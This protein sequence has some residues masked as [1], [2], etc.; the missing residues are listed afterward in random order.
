MKSGTNGSNLNVATDKERL[1]IY[2]DQDVK[3]G[4]RQLAEFDGRSM[5]NF[6]EQAIKAMVDAARQS[7]KIK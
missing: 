5:S 3:E 7:G 6:V 1:M 2:I 4:L